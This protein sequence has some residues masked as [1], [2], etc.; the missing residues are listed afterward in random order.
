MILKY[1]KE[2]FLIIGII[3]L[4]LHV[5]GREL[6]LEEA[7]QNADPFVGQNNELDKTQHRSQIANSSIVAQS[8]DENAKQ[9]Q[10][11]RRAPPVPS[12]GN[13]GKKILQFGYDQRGESS[14]EIT[15]AF[16]QSFTVCFAF[17]IDK[18]T[19]DYSEGRV[20]LW[21][22]EGDDFGYVWIETSVYSGNIKILQ[23]NFTDEPIALS[24]WRHLCYSSYRSL[25]MNG[26]VVYNRNASPILGNT[27]LT[28]GLIYA[29]LEHMMIIQVNVFSPALSVERMQD[30]TD[31]EKNNVCKEPGNVLDWNSNIFSESGMSSMYRREPS[32]ELEKVNWTFKGKVEICL[33]Y[34]SDAADE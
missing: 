7:H 9:N 27:T 32:A 1:C 20:F 5:Q 13:K 11:H 12:V 21:R 6:Q 31:R 18:L 15:I 24:T 29:T 19:Q 10:R 16:N 22:S 14:V 4:L 17:M 23:T 25:V 26:R 33:L 2:C 3:I 34:T 8:Q 30:I 28:I